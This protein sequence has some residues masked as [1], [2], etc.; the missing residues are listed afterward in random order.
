[1]LRTR[2]S[3]SIGR[4]RPARP[5][6]VLPVLEALEERQVPTVTYHG[7]ALLSN[8]EVQGI[9]YGSDWYNNPNLY[10]QTYQFEGYLQYQ[11]NSPYMDM[12]SK[13]GY[14]VGRGSDTAGQI[15]LVPDTTYGPPPGPSGFPFPVNYGHNVVFDSDIRA[16]LQNLIL[17][18][19]V[20]QPD[21]NRLYVVFVPPEAEVFNNNLTDPSHPLQW[22]NSVTDFGGYHQTFLGF[23]A[24]YQPT[25]IHYAV[26]DTPGGAVGNLYG[27]GLSFLSQFDEMTVAASHEISEAVTDPN[28]NVA[29]LGWY[30]D[31]LNQEIGDI[32]AGQYVYLNGYAVQKQADQNDGAMSPANLQFQASNTSAIAGFT[33]NFQVAV[34]SDSTGLTK[35]NNLVAF[36][37]WGDGSGSLTALTQDPSGNFYINGT[38]TYMTA[39]TFYTTV[40]VLDLTNI[41]D[42]QQV[43]YGS[44]T[45]SYL[46]ILPLFSGV[47][48]GVGATAGDVAAPQQS[49]AL[50]A[51]SSSVVSSAGAASTLVPFTFNLS[52]TGTAGPTAAVAFD[53]APANVAQTD[54]CFTQQGSAP[55]GVAVVQGGQN[56]HL[57]DAVFATNPFDPLA[58]ALGA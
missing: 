5:R 7:G 35:V 45:A 48:V 12:L 46:Q 58:L 16:N 4:N 21:A 31:G 37:N 29:T 25:L 22:D 23:D 47:G 56:M 34:G 20:G 6:T 30:D 51:T 14:N 17:S 10:N 27:G 3:F 52:S 19:S 38:H 54:S 26:V 57:T 1:M 40:S 53:T 28:A 11:V 43:V 41:A 13:A 8:V 15:A 50:A 49:L 32:V 9:Y 39:G 55:A 2:N 24:S 36:I 33:S 44:V 42:T 18:V